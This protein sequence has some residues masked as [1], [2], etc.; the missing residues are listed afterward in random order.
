MAVHN[1][2]GS[3]ASPNLLSAVSAV[4][5]G[6]ALDCRHCGNGG[7]LF[8]Q[9]PTA[10]DPQDASAIASFEASHDCT[11]WMTVGTYTATATLTGT[12]QH[13][14]HFPY[15]RGNVIAVYYATA[16][17]SATGAV[18]MHWSPILG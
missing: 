15:V 8:W 3:K 17:F 14:G 12:A 5:T 11:A 16:Q 1:D 7:Y 2:P 6:S 4:I 9:M 18:S 13:V 10:D